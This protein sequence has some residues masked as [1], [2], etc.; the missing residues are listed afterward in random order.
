[1]SVPFEPRYTAALL[2][3]IPDHALARATPATFQTW[4]AAVP[5]PAVQGAELIEAERA[6]RANLGGRNDRM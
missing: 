5:L 1:M 3:R 4:P 6:N 2:R